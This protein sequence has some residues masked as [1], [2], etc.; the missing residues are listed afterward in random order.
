MEVSKV[1]PQINQFGRDVRCLLHRATLTFC[2]FQMLAHNRAIVRFP[3]PLELDPG[4]LDECA[5]G[6]FIKFA[7]LA[8]NISTCSATIGYFE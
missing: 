7:R 3:A 1:V 8:Q 5:Y 4:E 6:R 2:R